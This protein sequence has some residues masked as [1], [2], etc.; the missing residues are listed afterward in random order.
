VS[1]VTVRGG[2]RSLCGE[3][4]FARRD[5]NLPWRPNGARRPPAPPGVRRFERAFVRAPIWGY[6]DDEALV[7]G[8]LAVLAAVSEAV[9]R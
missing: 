4:L 3:P 5:R 6:P 8:Y 7:E 1:R 2:T 9:A